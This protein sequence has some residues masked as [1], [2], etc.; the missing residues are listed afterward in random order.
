MSSSGA[1]SEFATFFLH[2][3]EDTPPTVRDQ[4][5]CFL[6]YVLVS[7]GV[8]ELKGSFQF[9]E[10]SLTLQVIGKRFLLGDFLNLLIE[11][12]WQSEEYT[13]TRET[14]QF[15]AMLARYNSATKGDFTQDVRLLVQKIDFVRF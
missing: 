3:R 11:G 13:S 4:C 15:Q 9:V 14:R 1:L 2:F 6:L 7:K 12:N 10:T 8:E 5:I